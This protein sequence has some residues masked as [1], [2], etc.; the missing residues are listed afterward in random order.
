MWQAETN[1]SL[2]LYTLAANPDLISVLREEVQS[3]LIE[4]DGVFTST[5]LQN[6]KKLD[7]FLKEDE[8]YHA[9]GSSAL[10]VPCQQEFY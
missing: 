2:R 3:A 4:S 10:P 9:L 7:S 1:R 8:R 5:A 6:M